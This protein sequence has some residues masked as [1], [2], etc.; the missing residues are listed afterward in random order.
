M[1]QK[2]NMLVIMLA[3]L[4]TVSAATLAG[5]GNLQLFDING[6]HLTN[7]KKNLYVAEGT[8][9]IAIQIVQKY[10]RDYPLDSQT[11]DVYSANMTADLQAKLPPLVPVGNT[12]DT[13][14]VRLVAQPESQL[15][16]SGVFR[17]MYAPQSLVA[18]NYRISSG[19]GENHVVNTINTTMSLAEVGL[20]QF[21][22]FID[23]ATIGFSPGPVMTIDGRIHANGDLCLSAGSQLNIAKITAAGRLMHANSWTGHDNC[24]LSQKPYPSDPSDTVFIASSPD[25]ASKKVLTGAPFSPNNDNGCVNCANSGLNWL[26]YS[27]SNWNMYALDGAS[28]VPKLSLP[29]PTGGAAQIGA[30]GSDIFTG[31]SNLNTLRFLV[32]PVHPALDSA[33]F[34]KQKFSNQADIR[35][36]DGVWYLKDLNVASSWPGLPVWSD[37]PGRYTD[38]FGL[39]VGQRD[40]KERWGWTALPKRFSYYDYDESTKSLTGDSYGVVS[41]GTMAPTVASNWRPAHELRD[42]VDGGFWSTGTW[43]YFRSRICEYGIPPTLPYVYQDTRPAP[44]ATLTTP[45]AGGYYLY[46]IPMSCSQG[47]STWTRGAGSALLNGTRS[48]FNDP[49]VKTWADA[50][51][52]AWPYPLTPYTP[53][54]GST[55]LGHILPMNVDVEQFQ[56]AL[57]DITA[58]E[59][60]SYFTGAGRSFNGIIFVTATWPGSEDGYSPA[61]VPSLWPA[62]WDYDPGAR[63]SASQQLNVPQQLCSN[64]KTLLTEVGAGDPFDRADGKNTFLIPNCASY[65]NSI[66]AYVNAIRIHSGK[67]LNPAV[68]TKGLSIVSNIPVYIMGDFN[69]SSRTDNSTITPWVP[70]LIAGDQITFL[71]NGWSDINSSWFAF[72][73]APGPAVRTAMNTTYNLSTI[74][75]FN[76]AQSPWW[77]AAQGAHSVPAI[78][79]DW[80]GKDLNYTG[81]IVLGFYPVY[82]RG[83]RYYYNYDWLDTTSRQPYNLATYRAGNRTLHFDPHLEIPSHQPPGAPV[84][85]TSSLLNWK[86]H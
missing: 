3:I 76:V 4:A 46:D 66:K 42:G 11:L 30:W 2:G 17:G 20:F 71:S 68:L 72:S 78:I 52:T 74:G 43:S 53:L 29:I 40:L 38:S 25:M 67:T 24:G 26:A 65:P 80:A 62:Q 36:I 39:A 1:N 51:S 15:V 54:A 16:G 21:M 41:Y 14:S 45:A 86:A 60:G 64:A 48:G 58:G 79:E 81:S 70:S 33:E 49:H 10:L 77:A 75:G 83:G 73:N 84:F 7:Q 59:L 61:G 32:D 13:I 9:A 55:N 31:A 18:M 23:L 27:K 82:Y 6:I 5:F 35:I 19:S 85:F 47:W 69:S 56:L 8:R 34:R 57:S 50:N 37:H 63:T 22:Y 12:V 44:A 28:G